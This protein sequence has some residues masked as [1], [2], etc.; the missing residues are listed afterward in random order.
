M[1]ITAVA[2]RSGPH[3]A[4]SVPEVDGLLT[5]AEHLHEIPEAVL[6]A[7][8]TLTEGKVSDDADIEVEIRLGPV[9]PGRKHS[10]LQS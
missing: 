9:R 5:Q 10:Q 4:V 3:W 2:E 7:Y 8:R 1:K 6:D